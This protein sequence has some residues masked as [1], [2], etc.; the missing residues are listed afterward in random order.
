[1]QN[2]FGIDFDAL[3]LTMGYSIAR[4]FIQGAPGV[5][6][7]AAKMMLRV[8]HVFERH[9]INAEVAISIMTEV[10]KEVKDEQEGT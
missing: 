1:M 2:F 6:P 5:D 7:K 4:K 3:H 8:L 10:V 9:G